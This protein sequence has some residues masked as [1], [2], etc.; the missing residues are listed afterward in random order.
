MLVLAANPGPEGPGPIITLMAS[1]VGAFPIP[2]ITVPG[3]LTDV[4]IDAL[5]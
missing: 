2:V 3:E 1:V 4:E 5:S